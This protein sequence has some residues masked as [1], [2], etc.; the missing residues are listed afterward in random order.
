[1]I[2]NPN[3]LVGF[4]SG[5]G[6]YH[7]SIFKS[8][9]KLGEAVRLNFAITQ[10]YRDEQ[11]MRSLMEYFDCGNLYKDREVFHYRVGKF[12]DIENKIIPFFKEYPLQ[13]VKAND[14]ADFCKVAELMV[15]ESHLTK[16]GLEQIRQ[17]KAGMNRGRELK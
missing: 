6:C 16:D 10:H 14:F 5:E 9:T 8:L 12:S 2:K 4:T 1:V 3:W 11:L 7:V 17:I 13:G 15:S